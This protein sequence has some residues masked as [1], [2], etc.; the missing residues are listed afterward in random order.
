MASKRIKGIT[1]EI[2]A[3]TKELTKAIKDA[4]KQIGDAAYK[5]RDI[6][7]LLKADPKNVELLTQKQ[8][9]F[10]EAIEGT[11]K[12]LEQ[13]KQALEQ[14]KNGPQTE[15]TIRQQEA[16]GREIAE[17]EQKLK[18]LEA[19]YK[20]FGSVATQ[21]AKL[22][23]DAMQKNGQKIQEAGKG[24]VS[25]GRGMTT[26][27]T[28]PIAAG[29]AASAKEAISWESAFAG[30]RKTVDAT[31]EEYAQLEQNIKQMSTEM[32]SSKEEIAGVMEV[33]GQLGVEGVENLTA[34]TR[35][36]VM[37]GDT[38][39]IAAADAA[40]ALARVLNIT[41]DGYD[42]IDRL[43]SVVVDLGNNFATSESEIVNM[44]TRLAGAGK[45]AGFTTQEVFA[46]SAAMSSVG[47]EAEA[48][49]TAMETTMKNIQAAVS[50][51]SKEGA[52][53]KEKEKLIALANVAGMSAEAFAHA[54]Q[55]KPM[56]AM[57]AFIKGLAN[58][59]DEGGD[60]FA[61]LDELGMKGIRQSGMLQRLALASDMMGDATETANKA[62]N[63][64]T[65]LTDEAAKRY[66]TME[67]KLEQLK[68]TLTNLAITVGER[69]MPY[70]EKLIEYVDKLAEKFEGMSDAQLDATIKIAAFAAAIGP[71]L[72]VIG[73]I[74]IGI[75]KF[76]EALGVI[77]GAL[78]G[79]QAAIAGLG[80]SLTGLLGPL[81]LVAAAIAV[82]VHNWDEIK[83]A[84]GLLVERTKEHFEAI[85]NDVIAVHEALKA[86]ISAK[87]TEIKETA[88][89]LMEALK[90]ALGVIWE[91][92]KGIFT[93]KIEFIKGVVDGGFGFIVETIKGKLEAAREAVQW[94]IDNIKG[95][96]EGVA[97]IARTWGEHLID[98]FV[99]GIKSKASLVTTMVSGLANTV[100]EYLHFSEPDVGP[101][102]DFNT[103]M[104]DMMSQMAEQINAGVP[105]VRSAMQNVAGTMAGQ[106]SPDYSGQLASIDS[107][108]GKLA[109]AGGGN[110]TVPVYIG[111]QKFAQAVVDA[112][113]V[114]RL[115]NGGR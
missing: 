84:A 33:S 85:K 34:F 17:T 107:G 95:I 37:L 44:A 43:G 25:V 9:A 87:W 110:I 83:E 8:K 88:S 78:A 99:G 22:A 106:M 104:P 47:I 76:I 24:M 54:W 21:Q 52:T 4:E 114:N 63:E 26:Y 67:A 15:E 57:Q 101:L 75:G 18:S 89:T 86:Y 91:F 45:I 30:V 13:E 36:S 69:L 5:M 1:I 51:F 53:E 82:W 19:E 66:A 109:A 80:G 105:G 61:M 92:I 16:L 20:D 62:W 74:T 6:N 102:S 32:A 2:G 29:F 3:E 28:A 90:I 72:M 65:A 60:T 41:G 59:R 58:L 115:R 68:Q 27:V 111:Q 113:Q 56:D 11:K 112:N 73:G 35:T 98:N 94:I 79:A 81:A 97:N 108:I 46:M 7:K 31:E 39:N 55:T 103:W 49:G 12:K 50:N 100:R 40:T 14:L 71:V 93:E 10:T 70:I 23:A 42:K 96:M 64:N 48:G 77:K 38:T